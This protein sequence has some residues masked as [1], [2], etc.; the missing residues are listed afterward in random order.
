MT[1]A[2]GK[3][4]G[5]LSY[6]NQGRFI[7]EYRRHATSDIM[8]DKGRAYVRY[9][10]PYRGVVY[11][12]HYELASLEND[13][14]QHRLWAGEQWLAKFCRCSTRA[15]QRALNQLVQ[16]GFLERLMP[17]TGQYNAEYRFLFPPT[18]I[19]IS[20]DEETDEAKVARHFG[21][22]ARQPRQSSQTSRPSSPIYTNE[23]HKETENP[24]ISDSVENGP[25]RARAIKEMLQRK[26]S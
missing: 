9:H 4:Q 21:R 13:T 1:D 23:E 26:V 24:S 5:H 12:V 11:Q 10:S 6:P 8:S 20:A 3:N 25:A 15:V 19:D 14:H 17:A 22:V 18:N 7:Y 16:D 2:L